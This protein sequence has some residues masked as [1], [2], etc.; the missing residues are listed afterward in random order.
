MQFILSGVERRDNCLKRLHQVTGG[1]LVRNWNGESTPV[2]VGNLHGADEIQT[3]CRDKKIPYVYIDHGYF[4]RDL[5]LKYA[6]FCVSNYH[7]NDWRDYEEP[8][9]VSV[10]DWKDFGGHVVILPPAEYVARVYK[11][12]NWLHDTI[13]TVRKHT[14]RVIMVKRK[15]EGDLFSVIKDCWAV[16]SFGSVADVECA[17]Y[18]KPLFT[19]EFSPASPISLKDFTKIESPIYPDRSRWLRSLYGCEWEST[20]MKECWDRLKWQLPHTQNSKQP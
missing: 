15:H 18:G 7:C 1:E 12:S 3:E 11:A 8:P 2:V 19:S 6:R 13:E 14:D 4:R 9:K 10:F 16:V 17:L 5:N 20:E